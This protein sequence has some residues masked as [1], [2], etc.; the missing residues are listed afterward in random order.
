MNINIDIN[1]NITIDTNINTDFIT[2]SIRIL[3][4]ICINRIRIRISA[5]LT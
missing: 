1:T 4:T 3:N 5:D 2:I